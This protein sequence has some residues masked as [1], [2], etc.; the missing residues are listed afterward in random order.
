MYLNLLYFLGD[1]DLHIKLRVL[2][3][4]GVA[5]IPG[6]IISTTDTNHLLAA[7]ITDITWMNKSLVSWEP[8]EQVAYGKRAKE[9]ANVFSYF[10]MTI[11][12]T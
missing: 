4:Q 5:L 1:Y 8:A 7:S 2:P 11:E 12:T 3:E 9:E 10:L 6:K